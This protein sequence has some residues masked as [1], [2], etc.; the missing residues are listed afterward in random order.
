[1][2]LQQSL[3]R[4]KDRTSIKIMVYIYPL[5]EY[6][7]CSLLKIYKAQTKRILK[8]PIILLPRDNHG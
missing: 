3:L 8:F 7:L 5:S 4:T 1:M 2:S 6:M